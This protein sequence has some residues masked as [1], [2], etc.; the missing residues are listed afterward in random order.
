MKNRNDDLKIPRAFLSFDL[1]YN[2][3]DKIYF[4]NEIVNSTVKVCSAKLGQQ[5]YPTPVLSSGQ[6]KLKE[7]IYHAAI[8]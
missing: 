4:V 7:K 3:D 5:K 1:E 6:K 2:L 8:L